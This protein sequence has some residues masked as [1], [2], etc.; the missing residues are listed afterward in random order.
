[1][2]KG[3]TD[4]TKISSADIYDEIQIVTGLNYSTDVAK[5]KVV[6]GPED[7]LKI[8]GVKTAVSSF[9]NLSK[10]ATTG[11]VKNLG[12]TALEDGEASYHFKNTRD[13]VVISQAQVRQL[14]VEVDETV[15][16]SA[17]CLEPYRQSES[18]GTMQYM[19]CFLNTMDKATINRKTV[20][21]NVRVEFSALLVPDLQHYTLDTKTS[22]PIK[23]EL[24]NEDITLKIH[25]LA[26]S[27]QT[28]TDTRM[29]LLCDVKQISRSGAIANY[30]KELAELPTDDVGTTFRAF[31]YHTAVFVETIG[32]YLITAVLTKNDGKKWT[33][34][35]EPI[36]VTLEEFCDHTRPV[37]ASNNCV[38]LFLAEL[39]DEVSSRI[40]NNTLPMLYLTT[41][42]QRLKMFSKD[43]NLMELVRK[44][45]AMDLYVQE[46]PLTSM[47]ELIAGI[48]E[49]TFNSLKV[50]EKDEAAVSFMAR[51]FT[52]AQR[53]STLVR[54]NNTTALEQATALVRVTRRIKGVGG[55]DAD[56]IA[57]EVRDYYTEL[58]KAKKLTSVAMEHTPICSMLSC[59][60]HLIGSPSL[61]FSTA[62]EQCQ[63]TQA[64]LV[65]QET[66]R[67]VA[68]S[69]RHMI[70]L[71]SFTKS[72]Y[73]LTVLKHLMGHPLI[74]NDSIVFV[75]VEDIGDRGVTRR[76][77]ATVEAIREM[78]NMTRQSNA[79][80][81]NV[82]HSKRVMFPSLAEN[83]LNIYRELT[84]DY[85]DQILSALADTGT[86]PAALLNNA[87]CVRIIPHG[88]IAAAYEVQN[89]M[90]KVAVM[91]GCQYHGV[92]IA[93]AYTISEVKETIKALL[94]TNDE[95]LAEEFAKFLNI[96]PN[97]YY[98]VTV[99]SAQNGGKAVIRAV[100]LMTPGHRV[101][102]DEDVVNLKRSDILYFLTRLV[103]TM[104]SLSNANNE[105][106]LNLVCIMQNVAAHRSARPPVQSS[107][108]SLITLGRLVHAMLLLKTATLN[109]FS[110]GGDHYKQMKKKALPAPTNT[111]ADQ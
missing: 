63:T 50:K 52:N 69:S 94:T 60:R 56:T 107:A 86:M 10:N 89:A 78:G 93:T 75:D 29:V 36:Q 33:L 84:E 61:A 73:M 35:V 101:V 34:A 7:L 106:F 8:L 11:K 80:L 30:R 6:N 83:G 98:L 17:A 4:A 25:V 96:E 42:F 95:Q 92:V 47:R 15:V 31:A 82:M 22:G 97:K 49:I 81:L 13:V 62:I 88:E 102:T 57:K 79:M 21:V 37:S 72:S 45:F 3:I 9:G 104:D 110:F 28:G 43:T 53:N 27:A 32:E 109:R 40:A 23:L 70:T 76:N 71:I 44:T 100:N 55:Q 108:G 65:T 19:R 18:I 39:L 16:I 105:A 66:F 64:Q 87:G 58:N 99:P 46:A 41:I 14:M 48:E 59:M 103:N 2:F 91:A 54:V 5:A 38:G 77:R 26:E 74:S 12:D 24:D 1:V 67:S 68:T 85:Q 90:D 51:L 20:D 111:T